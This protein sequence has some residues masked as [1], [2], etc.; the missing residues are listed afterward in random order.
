MDQ[1]GGA[2]LPRG[3]PHPVK[4]THAHRH[5]VPMKI[6]RQEV[7]CR[8][9]TRGKGWKVSPVSPESQPGEASWRRQV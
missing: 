4:K 9:D 5:G 7:S 3:G 8:H 6:G 2:V 1:E